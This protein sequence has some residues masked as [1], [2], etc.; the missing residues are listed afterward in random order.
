MK[1]NG[2]FGVQEVVQLAWYSKEL[3]PKS[4]VERL[5]KVVQ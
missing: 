5:D 2:I 1:P 4:S 3:P